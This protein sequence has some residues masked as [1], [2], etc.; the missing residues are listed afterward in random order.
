MAVGHLGVIIM[1]CPACGFVNRPNEPVCAQCGSWLPGASA[2]AM[3][4]ESAG[5][6]PTT[7]QGLGWR[8]DYQADYSAPNPQPPY[9]PP[10]GGEAGASWD[11]L[12]MGSEPWSVPSAGTPSTALIVRPQS[13]TGLTFGAHALG[14]QPL[15]LGMLLKGGRYRLIQPF[16][17]SSGAAPGEGEPPLLVANDTEAPNSRV[18]VQELAL[19]ALSPESAEYAR[20]AVT[21][22][23]VALAHVSGLARLVDSFSEQ[24][25]HFLVFELPTGD[26]L[27]DRIARAH[28][29][30]AEAQVVNIGLQLLEVLTELEAVLPPIVHGNICPGHIVLRPSGQV[31]LVGIAPALLLQ[32]DG[33]GQLGG[34]GGVAGYAAPEQTRGQA[35]PRSDLYAV[36]AVLY[37]ALTGSPPP[38]LATA[39]YESPRRANPEISLE[40]EEALSRGLRPSPWQRFQSAAELAAALRPVAA[41]NRTVPASESALS[42]NRDLMPVRDARGHFVVPRPP[43]LQN[44]L[45]VVGCVVALIAVLGS[46]I[47]Y[48]LAPHSSPPTVQTD[49]GV[50]AE[51]AALFQANGIG[52]SAGEYVFD[53]QRDDN[54][55]K[56]SG[57]R[58][59]AAGDA[60]SALAYYNQARGQDQADA[61][62]TIYATD[63]QI[64]VSHAP[65]VTLAVGVA[66]GA[67]ADPSDQF[68]DAGDDYARSI[69][70]G[71][72]LAQARANIN[73]RL[74]GGVQ[75]RV[76]VLNS[77]KASADATAVAN[78]LADEVRAGNPQRLVGLVGWPE[79]AQTQAVISAIASSGLPMVSPT[80]S[81]DGLGTTA[82]GFFTIVPPN[83]LQADSLADAAQ[84]LG[85]RRIAVVADPNNARSV[86]MAQEFTKRVQPSGGQMSIV[87]QDTFH[88][89]APNDAAGT[90]RSAIA[91]GVDL[92]YLAGDDDDAVNFAQE[93]ARRAGPTGVPFHILVGPA[94]DT[95]DLRGIGASPAANLVRTSPG[96]L[97]ALYVGTLASGAEWDALHVSLTP[98]FD[99]ASLYTRQFGATAGPN[100]AGEAG[101][102]A[103][104]AYDATN[105]LLAATAKVVRVDSAHRASADSGALVDRIRAFDTTHPFVGM[106]GAIGF[107][108]PGPV[109]AK[110]MGI[111]QLTPPATGAAGGGVQTGVATVVGGKDLF[112]GPGSCDPT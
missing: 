72:A 51:S 104:L 39:V 48:A 29:R 92:L 63:L 47:L 80:A 74:P 12:Q 11:P 3:P 102:S 85:A 112:C 53:D 49:T 14:S 90:V 69:L 4:P 2:G 79:S 107:A 97:D 86:N 45:V 93:V 21:Q 42:A 36:C 40:L 111:L 68:V 19:G 84:L 24:G 33:A 17:V 95:L 108:G 78:L 18:L 38:S 98:G 71:V 62:A 99:F 37:A 6:G 57:A 27:S 54:V 65:Y 67:Q 61:E 56:Q 28:G 8:S 41:G 22:R 88:E 77:G 9:Y 34:A 83:R 13:A 16:S 5:W 75:L 58:A 26:L 94:A 64:L 60:R 101:P 76:L 106:G 10:S 15:I 52:M 7:D 110:A 44:P 91:A 70:Q 43:L 50:L 66:F 25:R 32:S 105:L 81:A 89:G 46:G 109:Q 1:Q 20:Q 30:L 82:G 87:L 23:L 103:T 31:A 100:G 59:L 35:S 73:G 96:L 55:L